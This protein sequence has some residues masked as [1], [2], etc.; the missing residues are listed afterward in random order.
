MEIKD[1]IY[2]LAFKMYEECG[3][4]IIPKCPWLL[5]KVLTKEQKAG[6]VILPQ[7]QNKI[8]YEGIVLETWQPFWKKVRTTKSDKADVKEIYMEPLVKPG[9]HVLFPHYEGLPAGSLLDEKEFR[10][11]RESNPADPEGRCELLGKLEYS[12]DTVEEL[13]S[14]V[15]GVSGPLP[16]KTAKE[17]MERFVIVPRGKQTMTVSGK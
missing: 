13:L 16:Q 8:V 10:L 2:E 3:R 9:D 1:Q 7:T 17:L 4:R 6:R 15:L 14:S 12:D 5:V 11:I